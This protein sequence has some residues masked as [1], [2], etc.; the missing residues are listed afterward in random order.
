MTWKGEG[1]KRNE[2]KAWIVN[3]ISAIIILGIFAI[4][5]LVLINIG[6]RVYQNVVI[7]N[8]NNFELRTSLS[9]VATKLRQTDTSDSIRIEELEGTRVLVMG[10]EIDGRQYET[11]IYFKEGV[12][13]ELFKE[14]DTQY[15]LDY[16][17]EVMEIEDF[18]MELYDNGSLLLTA[19]NSMGD[20]D[21]LTL[22]F[23]SGR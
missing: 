7:A 13:Y 3:V 20:E 12:L 16:G 9:F 15:N 21:E 1:M 19:R 5:C 4:S 6:I 2:Q 18:S 8:D 14:P 22:R 10:E 17:M 23:R 11:L